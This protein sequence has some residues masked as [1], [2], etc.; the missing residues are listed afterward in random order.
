MNIC[1]Y[2]HSEIVYTDRTCPLCDL[3]NDL[4]QLRKEYEQLEEQLDTA[5]TELSTYY[6]KSQHYHSILADIAPEHII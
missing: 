2:H 1:S 5:E 3:Q 6:G 4:V